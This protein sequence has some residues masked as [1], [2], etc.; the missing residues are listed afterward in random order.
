MV[1]LSSLRSRNKE[2]H[3]PELPR[4]LCCQAEGEPRVTGG[5]GGAQMSEAEHGAPVSCAG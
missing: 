1:K 2:F 5:A 3:L 4:Y